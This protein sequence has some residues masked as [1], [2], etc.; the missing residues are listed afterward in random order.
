MTHYHPCGTVSFWLIVLIGGESLQ[1]LRPGLTEPSPLIHMKFARVWLRIKEPVNFQRKF[2]IFNLAAYTSLEES[3]LHYHFLLY[4]LVVSFTPV[5]IWFFIS[6]TKQAAGACMKIHE[7]FMFLTPWVASN[8]PQNSS[9]AVD[10]KREAGLALSHCHR[11]LKIV[12]HSNK[13]RKKPVPK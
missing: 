5:V 11:L 2:H 4:M 12:L 6:I 1:Q 3:R 9:F 7:S 10:L 8:L 13:I